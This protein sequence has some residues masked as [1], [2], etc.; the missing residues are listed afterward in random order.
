MGLIAQEVQ[1]VLPQ[2][3]LADED[4]YLAVNYATLV[5]VLIEAMKEMKQEI[6]L[7]KAQAKAK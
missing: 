6:E 7:L 3:V 2:V 5:P 1:K 4:G